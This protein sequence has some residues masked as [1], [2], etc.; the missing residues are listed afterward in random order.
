MAIVGSRSEF[1][2]FRS[3][4]SL[5]G[6]RHRRMAQI[7]L[8]ENWY[9]GIFE[10]DPMDLGEATALKAAFEDLGCTVQGPEM[11]TR[12]MV[13]VRPEPQYPG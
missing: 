12:L 11:G 9:L 5:Q 1:S 8:D 7:L 10:V 3:A 2:P 6:D 4:S 13:V